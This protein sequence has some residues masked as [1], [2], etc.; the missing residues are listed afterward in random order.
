MRHLSYREKTF[1]AP[2]SH[3]YISCLISRPVTAVYTSQSPSALWS[4]RF[5]FSDGNTIVRQ[6]IVHQYLHYNHHQQ[7]FPI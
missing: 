7:C 3:T 5:S 6:S 1:S 2:Y 4:Q